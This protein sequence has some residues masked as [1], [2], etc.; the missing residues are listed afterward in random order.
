MS[1]SW[2]GWLAFAVLAVTIGVTSCHAYVNP[3]IDTMNSLNAPV[4]SSPAGASG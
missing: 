1:R 2:A 3:W 4:G